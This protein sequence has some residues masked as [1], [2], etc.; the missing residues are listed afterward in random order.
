[1]IPA[2][3]FGT[4]ACRVDA[5]YIEVFGVGNAKAEAAINA[6]LTPERLERDAKG[7]CDWSY[8]QEI[9]HTVKLNDAGFLSIES[10][11]NFDG[12]AHPEVSI[13]HYN[14]KI[15]DGSKI[16]GKEIFADG[17]ETVAKVKA[18]LVASINVQPDLDADLRKETIAELDSMWDEDRKLE[19][20]QFGLTPTGLTLDMTNN[21]P[22]VIVALAPVANLK[23]T[24][25]KPLL[26]AGSPV[27]PLAK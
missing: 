25:V 9:R 2:E 3:E 12:G 4:N 26:K 10:V 8:S 5:E 1:V 19:D 11:N 17:P 23:W 22:H 7:N 14:F 24:D 15:A 27:A 18:L 16:T 20:I 13:S 6:A 21:Y